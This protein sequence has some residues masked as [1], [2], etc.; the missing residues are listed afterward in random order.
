[1]PIVNMTNRPRALREAGKLHKGGKKTSPT[2][3]GPDLT[4]W[5]FA[6]PDPVLVD[7][8]VKA[9]GET[10][11]SIPVF[12][13]HAQADQNWSAWIEKW[14]AGGRLVFRGDG[15]KLVKH[16]INKETGEYSFEQIPHPMVT[17]KDGRTVPDGAHKGRLTV[18]VPALRVI[19]PVTIVTGSIFDIIWLDGTLRQYEQMFGDLRGIPFQLRRVQRPITRPGPNGKRLPDTRHLV[20]LI[21]DPDW[22]EQYYAQIVRETDAPGTA[23]PVIDM[24]TGEII[25]QPSDV[26]FD[27]A[28]DLVGD[29]VDDDD[30][31]DDLP[32][33]VWPSDGWDTQAA[34]KAY[35][36]GIA[37]ETGNDGKPPSKSLT[38]LRDK[39]KTAANGNTAL[40]GK[41]LNS[42]F[43][44]KSTDLT[45]GQVQALTMWLDNSST[46]A[47][48]VALFS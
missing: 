29:S 3:P 18:Q 10:P 5:R 25:T 44:V 24:D 36:V 32:T 35:L 28:W 20:E 27:N 30:D 6:S 22:V 46:L 12:L 26:D 7:R 1:M 15:A 40:A 34:L 17:T 4:Y 33:N 11:D 19:N 16:M 38:T 13:P 14:D 37:Y 23:G 47:D 2:R 9:F 8:F 43:G 31:D 41:V 21:P 45:A 48:D 42:V 39:L